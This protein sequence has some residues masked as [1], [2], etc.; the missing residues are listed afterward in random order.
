MML[1]RAFRMK[2]QL[3]QHPKEPITAE[4]R[5]HIDIQP[6]IEH[7]SEEFIKV[8]KATTWHKDD[9]TKDIYNKNRLQTTLR[10]LCVRRRTLRRLGTRLPNFGLALLPQ[11]I[12]RQQVNELGPISSAASG[13][14]SEGYL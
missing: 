7:N 3:G 1:A 14:S 5:R 8:Y 10:L 12:L 4:K 11:C 13:V 6:R 9:T 2:C